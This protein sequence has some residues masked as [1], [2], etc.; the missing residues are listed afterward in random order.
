MK[1][2]CWVTSDWF[3]D[4][5]LPVIPLLLQDFNIHWII[6]LYKGGHTKAA[7]L[8]YLKKYA[9]LSVEFVQIEQRARNPKT[10]V[11]YEFLFRRIRS[12]HADIT[13]FD[14]V[15]SSPYIIPTYLR[16]DSKRT[17]FAAHDGGVKSIMS[18][19]TKSCF[20]IGYGR[21]AK[22]IQMFSDSQAQEMAHNY[23]GKDI[24]VIPLMPKY[25]GNPTMSLRNDC[26]SFLSF[27]SLHVEKNIGLLIQA[28]EQLY[29]E[30]ERGFKVSINGVCSDWEERYQG[31]IKHPH[32]FELD[33]RS[34]DNN[35][36][37]NLFAHNT[38]VVYPYKAMSQSGAL[39]V[40][41]AYNKPVI[42]SDL[43]AFK[44][45]VKEGVNGYFFKSEEIESL[46]SVM[47]NCLHRTPME[48][49]DLIA[50]VTSYIAERYSAETVQVAYVGMFNKILQLYAK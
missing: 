22:H 28:A 46:K 4:V 13:Y 9:N 37:P 32:L 3:V 42:V 25:F 31:M 44:E 10:I 12:A 2:I 7:D 11:N 36:I 6:V 33:I 23:P 35:E 17:I 43:P 1:K 38:Y 29:D 50:S 47:R 26:K 5:D 21:H 30:G 27:G 18:R 16:L 48:Y 45:E 15:P 14:L 20:N 40:A 49:D 19:F 34:I 8:D 39:K 24:T 41:Y